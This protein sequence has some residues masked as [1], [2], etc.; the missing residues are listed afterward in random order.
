MQ[1]GERAD[2]VPIDADNQDSPSA[3]Y[4]PSGSFDF[5]GLSAELDPL[6]CPTIALADAAEVEAASGEAPETPGSGKK[7]RVRRNVSFADSVDFPP[8]EPEPGVMTNPPPRFDLF[9]SALLA[10]S[11]VAHTVTDLTMMGQPLVQVSPNWL[12][13]FGYELD[14]VIG[15]NVDQFEGEFTDTQQVSEIQRA[16]QEKREISCTLLNYTKD[17]ATVWN[18]LT[19]FPLWNNGVAVA[20]LGTH[21]LTPAGPA[22]VP[23]TDLLCAPCAPDGPPPPRDTALAGA[24]IVDNKDLRSLSLKVTVRVEWPSVVLVHY[25]LLQLACAPLLLPPCAILQAAPQLKRSSMT[26]CRWMRQ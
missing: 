24:V 4:S 5:K 22:P 23:P 13:I 16:M 19:L 25:L 18:Q 17:G 1:A 26:M 8:A 15:H 6:P 10:Q 20:Y 11:N 12:S 21:I 3:F 14:E 7:R 2:P 9:H